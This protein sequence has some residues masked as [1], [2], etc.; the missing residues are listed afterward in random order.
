[1]HSTSVTGHRRR[2]PDPGRAR[3]LMLG[4]SVRSMAHEPNDVDRVPRGAPDST[5]WRIALIAVLVVF[6]ACR[7]AAG[8]GR[9]SGSTGSAPASSVPSEP[10]SSVAV[11]A[12]ALDC[13]GAAGARAIWFPG[14][15]WGCTAPCW[16]QVTSALSW[17][18]TCPTRSERLSRRRDSSL[19]TIT[20]G[21]CRLL[22]KTDDSALRL[23]FCW[24]A[25]RLRV[26]WRERDLGR[27]DFGRQ[28]KLMKF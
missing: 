14:D 3:N 12:P 13:D 4:T 16:V 23:G 5:R 19:P 10:P 17:Q 2:N 15:R 8:T 24:I 11:T 21:Y 20:T 27:G 26:E 22:R 25:G 9:T 28:E 6:V 7:P 1:M 18:T